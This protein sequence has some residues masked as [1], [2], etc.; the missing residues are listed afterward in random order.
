MF[1]IA[2]LGL[3]VSSYLAIE[4]LNAGPLVC[5]GTGCDVVRQSAYGSLLG[6]PTPLFGVAYYLALAITA[7]K[8]TPQNADVLRW[9]LTLLTGL[10]L[11]F[12]AWLTYLEAFVLQAWCVWCVASA[13]LSV[14][15]FIVVWSRLPSYARKF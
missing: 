11:A 4:Y 12:S 2:I 6:V 10:G 1:I 13:I 14:L 9:P 15:A 8:L 3:L 5:L 7:V